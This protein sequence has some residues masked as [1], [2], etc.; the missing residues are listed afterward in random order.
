M[1]QYPGA[2]FCEDVSMQ[3]EG[4]NGFPGPLVKFWNN[5]GTAEER[6]K[7]VQLSGNNKAKIICTIGYFDGDEVHYFEGE[8][9]GNIVMPRAKSDFGFDPI[10]EVR[11]IG[12]TFAE[13]SSDEKNQ[14]SHR[15]LALKKLN[16]HLIKYS[17]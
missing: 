3:I 5:S 14:V 6:V 9:E 2:L 12:K 8:V 10:F 13:M 7:R 17:K 15:G 4:F 11:G 1:K 16:N